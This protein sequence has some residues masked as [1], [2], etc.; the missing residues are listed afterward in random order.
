MNI[1][2][3]VK[4]LGKIVTNIHKLTNYHP[5]PEL[6]YVIISYV[7][8]FDRLCYPVVLYENYLICIVR[9]IHVNLKNDGKKHLKVKS[10]Q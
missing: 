3:N 1:N 10:K 9:N 7:I 5:K 6:M 8:Q 2:E 4:K